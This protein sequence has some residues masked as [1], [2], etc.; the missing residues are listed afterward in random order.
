MEKRE[1]TCIG[2]P[3]GCQIT[4]ELDGKEVK[5]THTLTRG[6]SHIYTE[7]MKKADEIEYRR[8]KKTS[9]LYDWRTGTNAREMVTLYKKHDISTV[10]VNKSEY[11]IE[12]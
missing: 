3:M 11:E 1:L 8:A 10:H 6:S 4:V 2:C 5:F 7:Q 9:K 12:M